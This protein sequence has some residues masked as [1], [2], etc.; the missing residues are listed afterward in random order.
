MEATGSPADG[1]KTYSY[2]T[3]PLSGNNGGD[4]EQKTVLVLIG[5]LGQTENSATTVKHVIDNVW[6]LKCIFVECQ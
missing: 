2:T 1:A 4:P 6:H 3:P 5:D